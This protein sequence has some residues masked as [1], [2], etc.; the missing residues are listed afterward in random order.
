MTENVGKNVEYP[1]RY[2]VE[3]GG[4]W[5]EREIISQ[6]A[7][8]EMLSKAGAW[9]SLDKSLLDELGSQGYTVEEKFQGEESLLKF[10]EKIQRWWT[11][12]LT[13]LK[14]ICKTYINEALQYKW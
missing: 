1:I 6:L 9:I 14:L 10:L 4:V 3:K 8:W 5:V 13:N 12:F 7:A 11:T 2:G